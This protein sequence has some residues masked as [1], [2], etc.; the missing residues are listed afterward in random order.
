MSKHPVQL[1][2]SVPG[3]N[4]TYYKRD[5]LN[6]CCFPVNDRLDFA[7]GKKWI[8]KDVLHQIINNE[9]GLKGRDALLI[10]C[11]LNDSI[12]GDNIYR[13]HPIRHA[14]ILDTTER[15]DSI[16]FHIRLGNFVELK[17]GVAE[18]HN[19]LI[20][21]TILHPNHARKGEDADENAKFVRFASQ[22]FNSSNTTE[23]W[24]AL[25]NRLTN[26]NGLSDSLFLVATDS[27]AKSYPR[28]LL[29]SSVG[30]SDVHN[31]AEVERGREVSMTLYGVP[32]KNN[33][34]MPPKV[35]VS[36]SVARVS[37]PYIRQYANGYLMLYFLQ[38]KSGWDNDRTML[39]IV[40][41]TENDENGTLKF[42]SP[43]IAVQLDVHPH[44]PTLLIVVAL[45]FFGSLLSTIDKDTMIYIL[46]A[47]TCVDKIN[48]EKLA[49]IWVIIL[50]FFGSFFIAVGAFMA[51]RKLPGPGA[52]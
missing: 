52:G 35:N 37:G 29:E 19:E 31:E 21:N 18:A 30:T 20:D 28:F 26:L 32:G 45:F 12:S 44:W 10:Y 13:F 5:V 40:S 4:R 42:Q 34:F 49:N 6:I 17:T 50:K 8:A 41:E 47:H 7:F 15:G 43:E 3:S 2:F 9:D 1:F 16:T 38:L 33:Q 27:S 36:E 25:V 22:N 51:F 11:E 14:T 23:T 46:N 39:R 24:N 48:I